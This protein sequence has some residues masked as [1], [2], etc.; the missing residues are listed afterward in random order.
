MPE[1]VDEKL[2]IITRLDDTL[3]SVGINAFEDFDLR[4]PTMSDL[5]SDIKTNYIGEQGKLRV[6]LIP[7]INIYDREA[8][9]TLVSEIFL[10]TGR[11]PVGMPPIM[12]EITALVKQ[13][14]LM[15]SLFC[16]SIAFA[17]AWA[18]FR[19][20]KLAVLAMV[21]LALTLYVTV[22]LQGALHVEINAFSIAAF[23]LIIGIGV[24]SSIHLIHRLKEDSSLSLAEKTMHTG[25]A[26]VVTSLT[27]V[28]GFGSL[29]MIN[30]PGMA[31]LGLSV[32]I[33]IFISMLC[34]LLIVPLGFDLTRKQY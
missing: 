10:I 19:K 31:N 21:P 18:M 20:F 17:I 24:D 12:N 3:K 15:I 22:G 9:D 6:E 1:N 8:Y 23:P 29:A 32:A 28:V 30:H 7:A 14:I 27:T 11:Y 4:K 34:T 25:K 16:F 33:G 5:P 26:I 13:D 2:R